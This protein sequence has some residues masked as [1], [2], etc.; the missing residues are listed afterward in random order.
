MSDAENFLYK[1]IDSKSNCCN[2]IFA[3]PFEGNQNDL[4]L[5]EGQALQWFVSKEIQKNPFIYSTNAIHLFHRCHLMSSK[6]TKNSFH[7]LMCSATVQRQVGAGAG[8]GTGLTAKLLCLPARRKR[9]VRR[10][11]E[12]FAASRPG[13]T[14]SSSQR[15]IWMQFCL[16]HDAILSLPRKS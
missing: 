2:H 12:R 1:S 16:F 14:A 15:I 4:I 11:Q 6:V 8:G 10:A 9:G 3:V 13:V 7:L 5:C